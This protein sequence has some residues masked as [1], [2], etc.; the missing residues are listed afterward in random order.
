[1]KRGILLPLFIGFWGLNAFGQEAKLL[2]PIGH[3]AQLTSAQFS[4]NGK[5]ILTTADNI[6]ILW[7][8]QTAAILANLV[9]SS[10]IISARFSPDG[11]KIY[12][13]NDDNTCEVWSVRTGILL[14][15]VGS[16]ASPGRPVV[17][18]PAQG[19]ISF[20]NNLVATIS[21]RKVLLWN[22]STYGLVDS[23]ITSD[24]I[25]TSF[26]FSPN[27]KNC[28]ATSC[29]GPTKIWDI[30]K[31][32][33]DI[34]LPRK[35]ST[36]NIFARFSP[37]GREVITAGL[38]ATRS[39]LSIK[40]GVWDAVT[41]NLI[42]NISCGVDVFSNRQ[43]NSIQYSPDSK[44]I[45]TMN[46]DT[47]NIWDTSNGHLMIS[48]KGH[49]SP[50]VDITYLQ[51]SQD[52]KKII[53]AFS[54]YT[55]DVWDIDNG[56]LLMDVN[57]DSSVHSFPIGDG[58]AQ[59]S[60]D[61][62]EIIA[63]ANN[64]SARVYNV[65]T[66]AAG[67]VLRGHFALATHLQL[68][69]DKR[70]VISAV[71]LYDKNSMKS[72]DVETGKFLL[73]PSDQLHIFHTSDMSPDGK[74][75]VNPTD[76]KTAEITN[77]KTGAVFS[78]LRG[79]LADITG[80]EFS[81]DGKKIV[82]YSTDRTAKI[83]N[84]STGDLLFDLTGHTNDVLLARFS[85]DSKKVVTLTANDRVAKIWSTE[86]GKLLK[87]LKG[88]KSLITKVEFSPDS[89]KIVT[90]SWDITVKVWNVA[91]GKLLH[92]LIGHT[93]GI[94]SIMF[95]P[96]GE[97][98]VTTSDDNSAKIWDTES[99]KLL[100][101]LGGHTNSVT[102]AVF[103]P[104]SKKIA[105][106]SDDGT[107]KLWNAE[108]GRLLYTFLAVDS[109]DYLV[110]DPYGRY[111]GTEGARKLLYF[112]CGTEVIGLDQVKDQLWV[113]NLAERIM[114]GDSI[115]AKKLSDLHICG[116]IPDVEK[117]D[118]SGYHFIITP[119]SG[120]LGE[121]VVYVNGIEE[122]RYKPN[123]LTKTITGYELNLDEREL[124]PYFIAGR[125]NPVTVK[126]YT[127]NNDISSRGAEI[128]QD[129]T[130]KK[131]VAPNLYAVMI[132][133]SDYKGPELQ[134]KYAAK[135]A[136]DI[137]AAISASAKKLLDTTGGKEHV[138]MYNLT[139]GKNHYE[140]PEKIAIKN[141][142]GEIGKKATANDILLIFFAG[143]GVTSGE[144][145]Q[146]YFL[147]A[148]ASQS[149]AT[150]APAEV[151][152]STKE[153][154]EWMQPSNIK[155]QKRILILDACNSG[156]AINELVK[157]GADGQNYLAA[158]NDDKA[159]QIKAIDKLNE[160]SGL[161]ILAASASNQSAY[162]MGRYSQ[163]L[164]TYSLLKAIKQQPDILED[165]K[166]LNVSRWFNAAEKT[167][168]DMV[169][170]T[171]NRQEPQI[172]S[173]GNFNIGVVDQE[174]MAGIKLADE[175]P[176]FT[177]S[178]FQNDAIDDDDLEVSNLVNQSMNEISAR[179]GDSQIAYVTASNSP[180][181]WSLSGRY[182]VKGDEIT[183]KV[184]IKQNKEIKNKLELTGK[185]SELKA[186]AEKVVSK[187]TEWIVKA[188]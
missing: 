150:D 121:T 37:D 98:I 24:G 31:K 130:K 109:T 18:E 160:K 184:N 112:T 182:E 175:K 187:A 32:S 13:F 161:F 60:P 83:W 117:E 81:P 124:A 93:A 85:P 56:R 149:S 84:S 9:H 139:T 169:R 4:P 8:K 71:G 173:A 43:L 68:S 156:Q 67:P 19:D 141:V 47:V 106:A 180:D 185:K 155:A 146:F 78:V 170:E 152:I 30:A 148:D 115:N 34:S 100:V 110:T 163:G 59:F 26:E 104:D 53:A 96:D 44:K 103:Y 62:K 3:T 54:D 48:L 61:E 154:S 128:I 105:T 29:N 172:V 147:T 79:H 64:A 125:E 90:A 15:S 151:G 145:K 107:A 49:Q 41:G 136:E 118:K 158:R 77:Q 11:K 153:L 133:V 135:D 183:I 127:A 167:V 72:W 176:L 181:A 101:N 126:A 21:D 16:K 178:N 94:A 25:L 10:N 27:G 123:T 76:H 33:I 23:L 102:S 131:G 20:A 58:F 80:A 12:A 166:Y 162:E 140:L 137:S 165:N 119:Q 50:N 39:E 2:L 111:D 28:A 38:H 7:D 164:L 36:C 22:A 40:L 46:K 144:K 5:Y 174:V 179:G 99:G 57:S 87:E 132:G 129:E 66:K 188:K 159:E 171:G 120:G 97:K 116:L 63:T 14:A 51:F 6:A 86:T 92:D 1:M 114:K 65:L 75:I 186:L 52:G 42:S 89:K 177:A 73:G 88:H 138:F 82:T 55:V 157:V 122:K 17:Q 35:D 142:F 143:H 168:S 113:P 74:L 134:L 95:S 45:A 69:A 91:D 70:E 108:T